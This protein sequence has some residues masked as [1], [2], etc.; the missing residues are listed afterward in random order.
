MATKTLHEILQ[1]HQ[2]SSGAWTTATSRGENPLAPRFDG[3][4]LLFTRRQPERPI[5]WPTYRPSRPVPFGESVFE[6]WVYSIPWGFHPSGGDAS[7]PG[8]DGARTARTFTGAIRAGRPPTSKAPGSGTRATTR[9]CRASRRPWALPGH[10][11]NRRA[12]HPAA[13]RSPSGH[14]G[15]RQ[16][17]TFP[18]STSHRASRGRCHGRRRA[19]SALG[20]RLGRARGGNSSLQP[21]PRPDPP[22]TAAPIAAVLRGPALLSPSSTRCQRGH[23][24]GDGGCRTALLPPGVTHSPNDA[25]ALHPLSLGRGGRPRGIPRSSIHRAG[26]AGPNP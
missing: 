24:P 8:G 12:A 21:R 26:L 25:A 18:S 22:I 9:V 20:Q 6:A 5:L 15:D 3:A 10:G 23:A 1:H 17:C 16:E 13:G 4:S 2:I 11:R 14:R 7:K 19:A